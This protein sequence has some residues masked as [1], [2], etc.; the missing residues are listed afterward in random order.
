MFDLAKTLRSWRKRFNLS[1]KQA[2]ELLGLK[3]RT[4]EAYEHGRRKVEGLALE[5]LKG[6]MAKAEKTITS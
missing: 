1:R 4:L 6:R 5:G 2:A 3:W